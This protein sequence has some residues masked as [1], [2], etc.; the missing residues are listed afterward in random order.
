MLHAYGGASKVPVPKRGP[1]VHIP[2]DTQSIKMTR[3]RRSE[4][5]LD[6]LLSLLPGA[7]QHLRQ[8]GAQADA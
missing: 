8:V 5:V 7:L 6:V 3:K 2:I 4:M 1:R